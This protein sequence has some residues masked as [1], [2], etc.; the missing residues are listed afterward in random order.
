MYIF[1][2]GLCRTNHYGADGRKGLSVFI[3]DIC[4][5]FNIFIH[6]YSDKWDG[7]YR[8]AFDQEAV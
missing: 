6:A 7:A 2:Q 8:P 1:F 3:S 5:S 4:A